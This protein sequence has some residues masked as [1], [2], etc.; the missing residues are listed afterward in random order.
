VLEF[1]NPD[2]GAR[3]LEIGC[4]AGATVYELRKLGYKAWGCDVSELAITMARERYGDYYFTCN[5]S[6]PEGVKGDV[7]SFDIVYTMG[8]FFYV[9][10]RKLGIALK[11]IRR[12]LPTGGRLY[13]LRETD[14]EKRCLSPNIKGDIA[15]SLCRIFTRFIPVSSPRDGSFY[16][17]LD[18]LKRIANKYGF[19]FI[20]R[21]DPVAIS[22][23]MRSNFVFEAI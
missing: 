14:F 23:W 16:L 20:G 7:S 21:F 6:V 17:K 10:P 4:G 3:I 13:L 8:S 2:K 5:L 18:S 11:N 9:H 12:I 19:R 15:R 22:P 1:I